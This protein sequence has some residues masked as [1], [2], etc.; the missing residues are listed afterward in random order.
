MFTFFLFPLN[1]RWGFTGD[2]VDDAVNM[3]D[4]IDDA[5]GGAVEDVVGDTSPIGGHEV[6]GGDAAEG[7]GIVVGAAVAHDADGAHIRQHG[8]ILA[9]AVGAVSYTH[10]RA[11]E[12]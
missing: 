3:G 5:G 12:T 9:D 4:L 6:G 1:R 11:H 8:E 2:I 7:E 10:L